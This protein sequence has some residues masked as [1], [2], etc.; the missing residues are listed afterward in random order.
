MKFNY[1]VILS[2]M[3]PIFLPAVL[4]AQTIGDEVQK[5]HN[6][7]EDLYDQMIPLCSNLIS[8]GQ[9]IG[10]FAATFYIG[11]RVWK[12]IANAEPIDFFP[13]LRPFALVL[14]IGIFPSV[15]SVINGV[16]KPTSTV[17]G[18]LVESTHADV[19]NLLFQRE[20][21]IKNTLKWKALVGP[22]G[23]GDAKLWYKY[24]HPGEDPEDMGFFESI[25]NS[26]SLAWNQFAYNIKYFFRILISEILQ[27]FYYAASLCIDTIRTF[28]LIILAILGPIVFGLAVFDGF[29]HTL[30]V[31]LARYINIY[32]WLPVANIFG[33]I[34][35]KIQANIL[36]IDI[37]NFDTGSE[38]FF[39]PT[40]IAYMIFLIIAIIGYF[41]IPSVANY[42]VYASGANPIMSKVN[43][44]FS[45]GSGGT[46]SSAS[47]NK[48]G[49]GSMSKDTMGGDQFRQ[50]MADRLNSDAYFPNSGGSSFQRDKLSGE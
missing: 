25:G 1:R 35:N 4:K 22:T 47:E 36:K 23:E 14:C 3:I 19:E 28:H 29:Q 37:Q 43:R 49:A 41:T 32:M 8:I 44:G 39:N 20:A 27:L 11:Y 46:S 18:A 5:L 6:I 12:H 45:S 26:I 30:S 48:S 42:I 34:V 2:I 40:D 13:L 16:L 9:A 24:T 38:G 31:W 21:A 50:N 10:G 15:L 7:L 17:T 33:S